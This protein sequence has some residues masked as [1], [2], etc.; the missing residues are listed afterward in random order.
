MHGTTPDNEHRVQIEHA[1]RAL[2]AQ[3]AL[4]GDAVVDTA[5]APLRQQLAALQAPARPSAERKLVTVM[6]AD[7][8]GFTALS[9]TM[10]AESVREL[11]NACFE[12]LVPIVEGYGGTIDK[13]IGDEIMALF[14]APV[15]HEDHAPRCLGAALDMM[16][17]LEAFNAERGVD[18]GLHFGINSGRVVVGAV[19]SRERSQYSAMGDAV[20]LAARLE[21]ESERGDIFVG[22]TT[23][24]LSR[25][26][27]CFEP[28]PAVRVK[29]KRE[30]VAV[31]RLIGRGDSDSRHA[32]GRPLVGRE[33]EMEKLETLLQNAA[34]GRGGIAAIVAD[35]GMGKSRLLAELRSRWSNRIAWCEGRGRRD[36][37]GQPLAGL[38]GMLAQ[39]AAEC[40]PEDPFLR[41]LMGLPLSAEDRR[42]IE[43][44]E[45]EQQPA[46]RQAAVLDA[47]ARAAAGDALALIVEDA[48]WLD[49]SSM[50]VIEALATRTDSL[51]LALL[52]ALR[53]MSDAR[54][55]LWLR[56]EAP[57]GVICDLSQ[58]DAGAAASLIDAL[59]QS[60][61]LPA[62]LRRRL[63]ARAEGNP[64]FLE[65]LV[66]DAL[67]SGL[68]GAHVPD[69][70]Q[71]VVAARIDRLPAAAK[72]LL[73]T[74]AVVG[75]DFD[76]RMLQL[77]R[78]DSEAVGPVI[79]DTLRQRGL[80][81]LRGEQ[82]E[83]RL[84]TFQHAITHEVAYESLLRSERRALHRQVGDLLQDLLPADAVQRP[85]LLAGHFSA[86]GDHVRAFDQHSE[87]GRRAAE[88]Y[89]ND[90]AL[91]HLGEALAH[92]DHAEVDAAIVEH[93]GET[94]A[95]VLARVGRFGEARFTLRALLETCT[96]TAVR[97][98]LRRRIASSLVAERRP[99]AALEAFEEALAELGADDRGPE[100]REIQLERL[101]AL[102]F[103]DHNEALAELLERLGPA[104]EAAGDDA[105]RARMHVAPV[106][107]DLKRHRFAHVGET[108]LA[109]A[110]KGLRAAHD[111]GRPAL[112]ALAAFGIGIA[113]FARS[114]FDESV[115]H[116]GQALTAAETAGHIERRVMCLTYLA[117]IE[118]RRGCIDACDACVRSA[119]ALLDDSPIPMYRALALGNLAWCE[120]RSGQPWA[121]TLAE[122]DRTLIAS[123]SPSPFAWSVNL[124]PCA[125]PETAPERRAELARMLLEPPSAALPEPL[126]DALQH[127]A[128]G[129]PAELLGAASAAGYL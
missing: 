13:F 10:D 90:E 54:A 104:V 91:L 117:L 22:E 8:S 4:L 37:E 62:D 28:L 17:A 57:Q 86:A 79:L 101:W 35:A 126:T 60:E 69:S 105:Q 113:R 34:E 36:S 81:R 100:W 67:D 19:G 39:L 58:L 31:Y 20:N 63:V 93:V 11:I 99:V 48:H 12:R 70:V 82:T 121:E 125:L 107:I 53:P 112:V 65:E 7:I 47:I 49:P 77:L 2:D 32:P 14:G 59:P 29:G 84:Y 87:A 108:A 52:L 109:R 76:L 85:A 55:M 21:G 119:L 120:W 106:M 68:D 124:L 110:E 38:R 92:A 5:L 40:E 98:R 46:R 42:H 43:A 116:L 122:A 27:F 16:Q 24:R 44:L 111:S 30:P 127:I 6:F 72:S 75:R 96:D 73:Q 51:P 88:A 56:S 114:E 45:A 102:Y 3:R 97:A 80:V 64:F 78:G 103:G 74:A 33:R 66:R 118:R 83:N 71:A 41:D 50:A 25:A 1:I 123:G 95:E 129:R 128:A 18:L 23:W 94:R 26:R 15:A 61:A 89:A 115:R 9:E